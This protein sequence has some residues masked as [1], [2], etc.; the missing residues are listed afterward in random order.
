MV[1]GAVGATTGTAA[2]TDNNRFDT[3]GR[4]YSIGVQFDF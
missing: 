4:T 1:A 3:V 2:F